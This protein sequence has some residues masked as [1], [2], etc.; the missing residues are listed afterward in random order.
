MLHFSCRLVV[1]KGM[2]TMCTTCSFYLVWSCNTSICVLTI[3]RYIYISFITFFLLDPVSLVKMLVED[4]ECPCL[5][6]LG[7]PSFPLTSQLLLTFC[8]RYCMYVFTTEC[9]FYLF[10]S[11]NVWRRLNT[12]QLLLTFYLRSIRDH[13]LTPVCSICEQTV[14]SCIFNSWSRITWSSC[15]SLSPWFSVSFEFST[16][17]TSA[18]ETLLFLNRLWA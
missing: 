6:L 4:M 14:E 11:L 12:S 8:L 10:S 16:P 18:V 3:F 15:T 13:Y 9:M 1:E 5:F 7:H 17:D 2:R